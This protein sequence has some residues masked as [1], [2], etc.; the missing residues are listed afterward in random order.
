MIYGRPFITRKSNKSTDR[1]A[2]EAR[3]APL[4]NVL[5]LEERLQKSSQKEC[6][7]IV[8]TESDACWVHHPHQDALVVTTKV[9][10][11]SM[12][13][14]MINNDSAVNILY[15]NTFQKMG[16]TDCDV[17][18][19]TTPLYGFIGDLL[20]PRGHIM[21]AVT[22]GEQPC[23]SSVMTNFLVVDDPSFYNALF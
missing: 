16:F 21:L 5:L 9:G 6:E 15:I 7:D 8:F 4:T 18:S 19:M 13:Q 1:Y 20:I 3:F 23:T 22:I 12:H 10:N 11:S 14:I 17:K 2:R